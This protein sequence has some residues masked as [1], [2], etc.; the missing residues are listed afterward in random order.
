VCSVFCL[1]LSFLL[2]ES[3]TIYNHTGGGDFEVAGEQ[4]LGDSMA[5]EAPWQ[6]GQGELLHSGQL[7]VNAYVYMSAVGESMW[8]QDYTTGTPGKVD[9]AEVESLE[10]F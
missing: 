2:A 6:H 1:G 8:D 7:H 10:Q 3:A 9:T 4:N 5:W